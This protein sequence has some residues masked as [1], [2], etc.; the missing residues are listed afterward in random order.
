MDLVMAVT[1]SR[2]SSLYSNLT[3][4]NNLFNEDQFVDDIAEETPLPKSKN[5]TSIFIK[6]KRNS[7]VRGIHSFNHGVI[8]RRNS[9]FGVGIGSADITKQPLE[10]EKVDSEV[11]GQEKDSGCNSGASTPTKYLQKWFSGLRKMDFP[12]RRMSCDERT[13]VRAKFSSSVLAALK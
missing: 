10:A 6:E 12:R 1:Y 8:K 13:E 2:K 9:W 4:S 11:V 7:L 3:E 5:Q